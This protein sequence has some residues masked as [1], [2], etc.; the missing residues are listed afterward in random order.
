M[1][2]NLP[3]EDHTNLLRRHGT[4]AGNLLRA[5]NRQA[6]L[7]AG[8]TAACI[9]QHC[10]EPHQLGAKLSCPRC[11]KHHQDRKVPHTGNRARDVATLLVTSAGLW[12][13]R[14][15]AELAK[16]LASFFSAADP[17]SLDCFPKLA[18]LLRKLTRDMPL[19]QQVALA[20]VAVEAFTD[21]GIAI[22]PCHAGADHD[23]ATG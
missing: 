9:V 18:R 16:E 23:A 13:V 4:N 17:T 6:A 8:T 11:W 2:T 15:Q 1:Q 22:G 3:L 20:A 12:P 5:A 10:L 14:H 21:P 19:E 7:V